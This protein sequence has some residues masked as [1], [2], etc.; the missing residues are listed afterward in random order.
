V[1]DLTPKL[2]RA[3]VEIGTQLRRLADAHTTPV[4]IG[5]MTTVGTCD[6]S[7]HGIVG[8]NLGP[9]V[10]RHQHD[11]PV[12]QDATG[13]RWSTAVRATD[14][15]PTTTATDAPHLRQL[16]ADALEA[17][18]YRMDMRRGDLADA[19]LPVILP[20]GKTLRSLHHSAEEDATEWAQ[21]AVTAAEHRDQ[22]AATLQQV[23]S[24]FVHKGHPGEPCLQ[25]GWVREDTVAKWRAVLYP[26]AADDKPAAGCVPG[27]YDDCPNCPHDTEEQPD[28]R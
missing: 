13:A 1:P 16:I 21:R 18:D 28:A 2:L 7:T 10:L 14:D 3:V 20:L 9:C 6:A 12:H 15:A 22:L 26:P 25:T 23:L 17:A 8:E 5:E 4:A 11:G 19:V 27:P 24:H